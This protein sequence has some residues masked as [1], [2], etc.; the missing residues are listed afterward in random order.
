MRIFLVLGCQDDDLKM[1]RKMAVLHLQ[2][3]K[4]P[5]SGGGKG[6]P[7]AP[8]ASL[9][10]SFASG[11][12]KKKQKVTPPDRPKSPKMSQISLILRALDADR[13]RKAQIPT[14][15]AGARDGW[16]PP[17]VRGPSSDPHE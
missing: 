8:A 12:H 13:T 15:L 11:P 16:A 1:V 7:A 2:M 4:V 3:A 10:E 17:P 14:P 5:A 9:D 6:P